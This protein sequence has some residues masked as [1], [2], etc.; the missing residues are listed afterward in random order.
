MGRLLAPH[1]VRGWVNAR[2]FASSSDS[3]S[4]FTNLLVHI[5]SVWKTMELE[6]VR[7]REKNLILKFVDCH[8]R[9]Q[10]A[11]LGGADFGIERGQLPELTDGEFYWHTLVDFDVINLAG[12]SLGVIDH[13]FESGAQPVIVVRA[14]NENRLVPWVDHVIKE[15]DSTNRI[16]TVDWGLDY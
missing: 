1:G 10:A 12:E 5:D 4:Q 8:D 9:D 3:L 7:A 16:L 14:E 2:S 15:I 6:N 13:L 11:L